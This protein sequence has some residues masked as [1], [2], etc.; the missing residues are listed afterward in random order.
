M[1]KKDKYNL[2]FP[3]FL[4]WCF[5]YVLLVILR[6][7]TWALSSN[8][9]HCA[10]TVCMLW[11][12]PPLALLYWKENKKEKYSYR[13]SVCFFPSFFFFGTS[14]FCPGFKKKFSLDGTLEGFP[15]VSNKYPHPNNSEVIKSDLHRVHLCWTKM[16][17]WFGYMGTLSSRMSVDLK[18]L[19]SQSKVKTVN[20][21]TACSH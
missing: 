13:T 7:E 14:L 21:Q 6:C 19:L 8:V 3:S 16:D 15:K 1:S 4:L 20:S 11:S 2:F 9:R 18:F 5:F 17:L 12:H 10:F